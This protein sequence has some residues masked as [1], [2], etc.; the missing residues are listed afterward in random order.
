[1]RRAVAR[2]RCNVLPNV[3]ALHA[4]KN[5]GAGGQKDRKVAIFA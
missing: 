2:G 3:T 1:M 4:I 5:C